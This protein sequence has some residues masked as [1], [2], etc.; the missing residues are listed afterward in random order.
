MSAR[1]DAVDIAIWGARPERVTKSFPRNN[2]PTLRAFLGLSDEGIAAVSSEHDFH[3]VLDRTF[4]CIK[5]S[6]DVTRRYNKGEHVLLWLSADVKGSGIVAIEK[7]PLHQAEL[8]VA[9]AVTKSIVCG[10]GQDDRVDWGARTS[11]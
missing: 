3:V 5:V 2:A 7:E 1:K 10:F 8:S 11:H 6:L 9:K 4:D